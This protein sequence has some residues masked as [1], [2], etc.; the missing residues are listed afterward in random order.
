MVV[1]IPRWDNAKLETTKE[2]PMNPIKHDKN[3]DGSLRYVPNLF[4]IHG[5]PGNY[6]MI[7]KTWENPYVL[8]KSTGTYGDNDP[9]DVLELGC[10]VGYPGQI[11]QV[12][13]LGGLILVDEGKTDWKIFTIDIRDPLASSMNDLNDI[14]AQYPGFVEV[15]R[16]WY[17]VYKIP[18]TGKPNTLGL[19]GKCIDKDEATKKIL[20]MH[21]YWKMLIN[22][23]IAEADA[24]GIQRFTM[25]TV[26]SPYQVGPSSPQVQ[27]VPEADP[28]PYTK[29]GVTV[30]KWTYLP[31]EWQFVDKEAKDDD[32]DILESLHISNVLKSALD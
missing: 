25:T 6:G 13:V 23:T 29:P 21:E 11:K 2:V 17:T 20:E 27:S 16:K 28:Q 10:E 14:E 3:K 32:N 30:E 15:V 26:G 4:P 19:D 24:K 1:E 31:A 18:K 12:K 9:I 22:G 8:T 5:Y 7:P